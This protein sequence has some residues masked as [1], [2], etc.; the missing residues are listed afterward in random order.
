MEKETHIRKSHEENTDI[1][2][3]D[4]GISLLRDVLFQ[5]DP[6]LLADDW[7]EVDSRI[8]EK[9]GSSAAEIY[10]DF[11]GL[12]DKELEFIYKLTKGILSRKAKTS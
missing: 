6:E 12:T 8:E 5:I 7:D 10:Y 1:P 9:I 4:P 3:V 2:A 11:T